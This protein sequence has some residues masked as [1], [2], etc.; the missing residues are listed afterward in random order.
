MLEVGRDHVVAGL[1]S[2]FDR[3]VERIGA[4][5]RKHPALGAGAAEELVERVPGCVECP[6]GGNRHPVPCPPRVRQGRARK[7]IEGLVHRLGLGEAGGGVI[8][9]DH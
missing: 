7:T 4:V 8:E 1:D 5:E 9:V 6:L 2:P 3:Q